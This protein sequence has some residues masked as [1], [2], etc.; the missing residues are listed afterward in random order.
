[1]AYLSSQTLGGANGELG[2]HQHV[3]NDGK[4]L[5]GE[6]ITELE[7]IL[8]DS[9]AGIID[10]E[11]PPEEL[12]PSEE[13]PGTATHQLT[14]MC[15]NSSKELARYLRKH[16]GEPEPVM[17]EK[18]GSGTK[19]PLDGGADGSGTTNPLDGGADGSGTTNP[20][21]GGGAGGGTTPAPTNPL[22]GGIAE[23]EAAPANPLDG[24]IGEEEAPSNPLVPGG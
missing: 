6:V 20:L 23:E 15:K 5:I 1:M 11:D 24:G 16:R 7:K 14:Q 9:N 21:D 18:D 3:G 4:K 19:N 10:L 12:D 17:M 8:V 2:L 13:P 22:A